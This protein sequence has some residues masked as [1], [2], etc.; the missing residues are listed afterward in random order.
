MTGIVAS[1]EDALPYSLM[2]FIFVVGIVPGSTGIRDQMTHYKITKWTSS[3]TH[4]WGVILAGGDGTRLLPMTRCINGDDRPKQFSAVLGGET[5]LDQTRRRVEEIVDPCRTLLSLT[6]KHEPFFREHATDVPEQLLLIQ[7][8]NHGTAQAILFSILRLRKLDP[9]ATVAYFPSDHY[10]ANGSAFAQQIRDA[11]GE[12]ERRPGNVV[13][14]GVEADAPEESYGWIEPGGRLGRVFAVTRFGKSPRGCLR[15]RCS[16]K[17]ACGTVSSWWGKSV[18]FLHYSETPCLNYSQPSNRGRTRS[19]RL[20]NMRLSRTFTIRPWL[21]TFPTKFYRR[22]L[23][24]CRSCRGAIWDGATSA[25]PAA[26]MRFRNGRNWRT[27]SR[28]K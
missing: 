21:E 27:P 1:T 11:F 19:E 15:L 6:A 12:A 10:F 17:A 2:G 5:L 14:L 25:N 28:R 16:I 9:D 20:V 3:Q 13:L 7:P 23:A 22:R 26:S 18:R 4:R 24:A 8:Y